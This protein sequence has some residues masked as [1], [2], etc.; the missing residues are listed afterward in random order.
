MVAGFK[1]F[2]E[3]SYSDFKQFFTIFLKNS[4][5]SVFKVTHAHVGFKENVNFI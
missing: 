5:V 1:A 3:T 2:K 4:I